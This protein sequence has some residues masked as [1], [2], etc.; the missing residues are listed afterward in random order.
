[1]TTPR[2]LKASVRAT[3][4]LGLPIVGAHLAQMVMG[5]TDTIMLGW[6]GAAPLAAS[7]LGTQ[8]LMILMLTGAGFAQA[9]MPMAATA[10]GQGNRAGVRRATR[11]GLWVVILFSIAVFPIMWFAEPIFIALGQKPELT[12]LTDDY[13]VIVKW[14]LFPNLV[15]MVLRSFLTV[16][17]RVS[18]VLVFT[19]LAAGLNAVLNYVFIFGNWGMPALGIQG[20]AVATLGSASLSALLLML[21]AARYRPVRKY[22][23]FTH[24]WRPDWPA[25]FEVI[26]LGWPIGLAILAEFGLFSFAA[27]MMGWFG[28]IQLAAHGIVLQII[29]V[30]FMVPLGLSSAGTVLLGLAK[31]KKDPQTITQD[32]RG[33]LLVGTGFALMTATLLV[34]VP[35]TLI[36]AFLDFDNPDS[37]KILD[38]A[39]PLLAVAAAF[40]LVDTLQA[41]AAG[42]LR[43]LSDTRVPMQIAVF[44]YWG[45]GV[46]SAYLLSQHT[47]IG[48]I[49]IWYGLAI[50]LTVS[51]VLGLWRYR[52]RARLGLI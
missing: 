22:H 4:L 21:Y 47:P 46:P 7:V 20:A 33:V 23:I 39:I 41:L 49:G 25:F 34:L 48:A 42:L 50:G 31:G 32:G 8:M 15:V 43:G 3:L 38:F 19:L 29:S 52:N 24:F 10:H 44:A 18:V 28:V 17:H 9:V 13:M 11:M 26:R 30:A 35:S 12:T 6:L 5:I 37:R 27:I 36:S 14:A 2:T 1:M 51:S 40:Q 45:I 16:L